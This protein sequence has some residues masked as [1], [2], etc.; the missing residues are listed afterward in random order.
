MQ[1]TKEIPT[2]R[3]PSI[4]RFLQIIAK[5]Y[6]T[7]EN[8]LFRG[9]RNANWDLIP[10]I[11][12]NEVRVRAFFAHHDP[13]LEL[14]NEFRRLSASKISGI[15]T[16]DSWN[17]IALAQHHG[18]PTRLLDWSSNPLVALWFAVNEQPDKAAPGI[19]WCLD[20][21]NREFAQTNEYEPLEVPRTLVFR[22][23]HHDSRIIAQSG[24]F[25]VHKKN[26]DNGKYAN[27]S[28]VAAHHPNMRKILIP[29]K[30][31]PDIRHGLARCGITH[32]SLFPDLSGL[33]Q[34]LQWRFFAPK[35]ETMFDISSIV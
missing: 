12:R 21:Q 2:E 5:H 15:N 32:A 30:S 1:E 22:P 31:F 13:E 18:L 28:K 14:F 23:K 20:A 16:Q 33:C 7:N 3:A 19:V 34:N 26:P 27:L 11:A 4:P 29:A 24:W 17:I 10:K 6:Q 35:D 9:Q 8:T 25:T